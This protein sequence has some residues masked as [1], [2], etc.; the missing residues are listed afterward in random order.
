MP[1]GTFTEALRTTKPCD[2]IL[3]LLHTRF[4]SRFTGFEHLLKRR[5]VTKHSFHCRCKSINHSLI[6]DFRVTELLNS[7]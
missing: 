2:I 4:C 3:S 7:L 1:D 5:G 6:A